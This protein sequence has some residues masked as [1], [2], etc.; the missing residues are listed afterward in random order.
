MALIRPAWPEL[1]D[2]R[3]S[4]LAALLARMALSYVVTPPASQSAAPGSRVV[5]EVSATGTAPLS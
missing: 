3:V 1:P 5:L 4:P 2:A